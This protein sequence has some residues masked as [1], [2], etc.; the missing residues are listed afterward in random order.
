M[1]MFLLFFDQELIS[2]SLLFGIVI[3]YCALRLWRFSFLENVVIIPKYVAEM[4]KLCPF[5][6]KLYFNG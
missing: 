5:G 1:L 6:V 4:L 3:K 2:Q